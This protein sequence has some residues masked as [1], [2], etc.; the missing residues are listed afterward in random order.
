MA[1]TRDRFVAATASSLRSR[2]YAATGLKQIVADSGARL[3]SLYH[4]FPGG[5]EE[6]AEQALRDAG[7]GYR[8]L[9][10]TFLD[11]TPDVVQAVDD[12]FRGAADVLEQTDYVDACPIATVALEVAS[13]NERLR[14]ATADV[15]ESW[16]HELVTRLTTAGL[17]H[18]RS[19]ELA[20]VVLGALEG[21]FVLSRAS[22]NT[23][24]M[25][26]ARAAVTRLLRQSLT[27]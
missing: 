9:A 5:K 7:E 11:A 1:G 23:E 12:F 24:A 26:A 15:F 21:G 4:F 2:G 3:G 22:K 8:R 6:L 17:D 20:L 19:R 27:G 25:H 16:L 14:Q 18:G 10:V 13:T